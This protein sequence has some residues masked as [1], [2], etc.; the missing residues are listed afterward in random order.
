MVAKWSYTYLNVSFF[1][2]SDSN[3]IT[4]KAFDEELCY[5]ED[6]LTKK[7]KYFFRGIARIENRHYHSVY[8]LT[9]K[10]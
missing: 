5:A 9:Q 3:F 6:K 10:T 4:A 7:V 2:T 1:T 8:F